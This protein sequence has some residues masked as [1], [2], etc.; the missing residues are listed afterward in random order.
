M[1]NIVAHPRR[2]DRPLAGPARRARRRH[3]PG[4]GRGAGARDPER[5]AERGAL[6]VATTHYAE[7]KSYAYTTPGVANASVEFDVET[8][9]PTYRLTIGLP[10]RSNALA[11]ARG[12]ACP[13]TILERARGAGLRGRGPGR[14]AAGRHP[15]RARAR[16]AG[17]PGAE[18]EHRRVADLA[19]QLS[20]AARRRRAREG[21]ARSERAHARGRGRAGRPARAAARAGRAG[22]SAARPGATTLAPLVREVKRGRAELAQARGRP[23]QPGR[24]GRPSRSRSAPGSSTAR[25]GQ[26]GQ[27]TAIAGG[28]GRRAGRQLQDAARLDELERGDP[29][30]SAR[31]QEPPRAT[32]ATHRPSPTGP[33]PAVAD[34]D[35]RLARRPGRAGARQVPERRLPGRAARRSASCMGRAPACC[36]RSCAS[37]SPATRWSS[38]FDSA[39]AARGRRRRHGRRAGKLGRIPEEMQCGQSRQSSRS[40]WR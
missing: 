16:R 30:A 11:I 19:R 17:P 31:P 28:A 37:T 22:S 6:V 34:R 27:V 25:L 14:V 35:P 15:G 1:T 12:S 32:R 5:A 3:R 8:L 7:L 18:K 24:A 21:A 10:G 33:M 9:S 36:G 38:S 2:G 4:R 40:R 29:R 23:P 26:V 13:S 20:Q 39:R